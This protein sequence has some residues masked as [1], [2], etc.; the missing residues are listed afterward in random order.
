MRKVEINFSA[1]GKSS[2]TLEINTLKKQ[3]TIGRLQERTL[4]SSLQ[5][6]SIHM[7]GE[8]EPLEGSGWMDGY[9][10]HEARRMR[11]S[12]KWKPGS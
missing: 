5:E 2:V 11:K 9:S 7:V 6:Q 10:F 12:K 3:W 1:G 4:Q 8:G